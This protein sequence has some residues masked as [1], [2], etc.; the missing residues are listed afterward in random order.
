MIVHV[1]RLLS[2]SEIQNCFQEVPKPNAHFS[3]VLRASVCSH[4]GGA[5]NVFC[6]HDFWDRCRSG[7]FCNSH[8]RTADLP[9]S[10]QR[11]TSCNSAQHSGVCGAS[12][13]QGV[14]GPVKHPRLDIPVGRLRTACPRQL[15]SNSRETTRERARLGLP[16]G[17]RLTRDAIGL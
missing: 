4:D 17:N 16:I 1:Y 9:A 2:H 3:R 15:G 5:Y 6:S 11:T 12:F 8:C 7:V 13:H 14:A 10:Q